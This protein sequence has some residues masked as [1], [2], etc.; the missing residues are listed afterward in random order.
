MS[1][2][3]CLLDTWFGDLYLDELGRPYYIVNGYKVKRIMAVHDEYSWECEEGI[4]DYVKE[5]AVKAI[6]KAGEILKLS[7]P[8]GGEGKVGRSWLDVH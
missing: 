3:S 8:L 2:A 4:E 5:L 7:L 1:Y 6:E